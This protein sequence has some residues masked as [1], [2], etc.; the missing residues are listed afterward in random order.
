[1]VDQEQRFPLSSL[2]D[3]QIPDSIKVDR[4]TRHSNRLLAATSLTSTK[5]WREILE[6]IHP[7]WR[8]LSFSRPRS[9]NHNT[10]FEDLHISLH[11]THVDMIYTSSLSGFRNK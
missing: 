2:E 8:S 5:I 6:K 9:Q 7:K 4:T 10:R 11:N 1:M 3:N